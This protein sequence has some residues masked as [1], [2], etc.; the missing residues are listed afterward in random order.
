[1]PLDNSATLF[2]QAIREHL[3][4]RRRNASLE[5]EMPLARYMSDGG[6]AELEGGDSGEEDT[7]VL[8]LKETA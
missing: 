8:R 4:L 6:S 5:F 2:S 7:G 3:E 1:M